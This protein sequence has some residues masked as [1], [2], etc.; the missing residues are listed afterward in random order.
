MPE[1]GNSK[2]DQNINAPHKTG[3][4]AATERNVQIVPKPGIE[5][6]MPSIPEFGEGARKIGCF[7]IRH[8]VKTKQPATTDGNVGIT[9]AIGIYLKGK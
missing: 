5:R 4:S 7:E 6:N 9:L 8:Q 3:H 2:N 1:S